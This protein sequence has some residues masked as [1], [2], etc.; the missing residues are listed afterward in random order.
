VCLGCQKLG[1][2]LLHGSVYVFSQPTH[3]QMAR[4]YEDG[5]SVS[6]NLSP[7][8]LAPVDPTTGLPTK[9][10]GEMCGVVGVVVGC[11]CGC[12]WVCV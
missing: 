8:G 9:I 6:Y 2:I 10:V 1:R 7:Q 4:E 12:E 3:L 5:Y 11:V